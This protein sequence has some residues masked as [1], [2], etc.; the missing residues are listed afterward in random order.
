MKVKLKFK[1][2]FIVGGIKR[3]SNYIE[4]IDYI[5]GNV[6]R[7]AF[8]RYI[9]NNCPCFRQDEVV[10]VNGEKHKNWVYYRNKQECVNC[11]LK[12]V[13]MNFDKIKFSFFYPEGT[14]II[15]LTTMRC[16]MK[17]EHGLIDVLIHKR[18]CP[19]C[20]RLGS[21]DSRV[22]AVAGYLKNGQD[23]NV[24]KSLHTRTA[25]DR[26]TA[27]AKDGMLFSVEAVV[28]TDRENNIIYEGQI[29][30][31]GKEDI[32]YVQELRVGKY[33]SVG[34]GRCSICIEDNESCTEE[35]SR[36][37]TAD[38]NENV[39]E[40][41][42][43][44]TQKMRLFSEKYKKHNRITNSKNY[45]AV[46]LVADAKLDFEGAGSKKSGCDGESECE[47]YIKN[48]DFKEIWLNSL[49]VP[50][51]EKDYKIDKVYAEVF[52]FRGY[53]TSKVGDVREEPVHM[54]QKGSVIVFE[55]EKSF[56]ETVNYF[57]SLDGFGLDVLNGFGQFK[58]HFGL[59]E[60][61]ND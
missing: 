10:T 27:T 43:S 13:C 47:D 1:S 41:R 4:T 53:D 11:S 7:A 12:N 54:V 61:L 44:I 55:T 31:I 28:G 6:L 52:N 25:I 18:E 36:H 19:D 15:P 2:P 42:E 9:L 22:E 23:Y 48:E 56:D 16:K 45:F 33:T 39:A 32:L 49:N 26:Y 3:V 38:K 20:M 46:K 17:P 60:D 34:F 35:F 8:S 24:K 57:S 40:K 5:P 58:F 29:E 21:S 37:L 50:G 30:G 59:G 51:M 14:D